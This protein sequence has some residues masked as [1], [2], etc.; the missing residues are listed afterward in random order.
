[1][2][3]ERTLYNTFLIN[4]LFYLLQDGYTAKETREPEVPAHRGED[5]EVVGTPTAGSPVACSA[6][7]YRN[8]G[9]VLEGPNEQ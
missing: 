5:H 2:I 7:G 3:F 9:H 6:T 4:P 8:L 1:M